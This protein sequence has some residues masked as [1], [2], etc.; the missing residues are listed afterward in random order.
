MSMKEKGMFPAQES[1]T[2]TV[3][4]D[5]GDYD[6]PEPTPTIL[7]PA[8]FVP[9]KAIRSKRIDIDTCIGK[10]HILLTKNEKCEWIW[11]IRYLESPIEPHYVTAKL[12]QG[13]DG[14]RMIT[15][16]EIIQVAH[17]FAA[18]DRVTVLK[19]QKP[20]LFEVDMSD[21]P[22][23]GTEPEDEPEDP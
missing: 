6:P 4:P 20:E 18:R 1:L 8:E 12:R 21:F 3:I 19:K 2:A 17:R 14:N 5:P 10:C 22:W 15:K 23:P 13:E 16:E 11:L 7:D 9:R